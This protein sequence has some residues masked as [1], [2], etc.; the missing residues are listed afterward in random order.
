MKNRFI[1]SSFL[2]L[3]GRPKPY[4]TVRGEIINGINPVFY[5]KKDCI[6]DARVMRTVFAIAVL[7]WIREAVL[8]PQGRT[9][10]GRFLIKGL[11][12]RY[13]WDYNPHYLTGLGSALWVAG[14]WWKE[15]PIVVNAF[16][17]YVD[18]LFKSLKSGD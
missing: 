16:Y 5:E 13:S 15:A 10:T 12:D 3:I 6:L 18:F 7:A 14:R 1:F 2:F 17:Q 8:S 11:C 9:E 4:S